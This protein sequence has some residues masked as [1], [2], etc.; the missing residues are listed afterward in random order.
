MDD[1]KFMAVAPLIFALIVICAA[2][3]Q[4]QMQ[5]DK[6]KKNPYPIMASVEQYMMERDA[7]IALARSAAPENI[8]RDATVLVMGRR[9]YDTV[10]EGK[11]G[12]VCL[13]ERAW[14][15]PFDN[16]EFWNP[17]NRSPDCYNPPAARTV[18]PLIK[19]RTE[20]VLAGLS[21]EHIIEKLK[22]AKAKKELLALEPG[23]MAYMMSKQ[24]Y[25]TDQ[26]D[27]NVAH[28]MFFV[29]STD[30]ATWGANAAQSPVLLLQQDR[31]AE[32]TTFM[33]PVGR[34]SDGTA[35]PYM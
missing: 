22:A 31:I 21:K 4:T 1:K 34:W 15:A 28:I 25:L 33:I 12:F 24:A 17:K 27:H 18:L 11:N 19:M 10:V 2:P 23:A 13:V 29:P 32:I 35:A 5:D 3:G 9:G 26:D 20:M 30:P 8:S 6:D 14:M 7:E 16:P